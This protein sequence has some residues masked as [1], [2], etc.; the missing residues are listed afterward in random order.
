MSDRNLRDKARL[1]YRI[2][3]NAGKK[4]I[5]VSSSDSGQS[6]SEESD[7]YEPDPQASSSIDEISFSLSQYSISTMAE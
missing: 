5:V 2:L 4:V 7:N 1:D 6:E 3:H